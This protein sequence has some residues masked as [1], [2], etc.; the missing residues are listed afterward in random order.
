MRFVV[1]L[2][3]LASISVTTHGATAA[4]TPTL[5]VVDRSPLTIEGRGFVT[6]RSVTVIVK[7]PGVSERRAPRAN[8]LGR[9]RVVVR[10][11]NLTGPLRCAVG[12]VIAAR[13]E[14]GGLVLWRPSLPD[15]PSPLRPP[16][17]RKTPAA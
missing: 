14:G 15:C 7:A 12:V 10:T 3:A 13:I 11:V 8:E 5:R 16:A 4:S 17:E 2:V 1:V 6:G 9:F